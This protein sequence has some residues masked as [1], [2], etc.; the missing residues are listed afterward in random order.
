MVKEGSFPGGSLVENP[1][2]KAR[3]VGLTP[4]PGT[5]HMPRSY[6]TRAPQLLSCAHTNYGSP[7]ALEPTLHNKRS[8]RS[9][10]PARRS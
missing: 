8:H 5:S 6:Y 7:C 1:P 2:A 10:K 4:G 9:E 3:D